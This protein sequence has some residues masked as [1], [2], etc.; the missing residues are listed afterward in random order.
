MPPPV[1]AAVRDFLTFEA[2]GPSKGSDDRQG[3]TDPHESRE[4]GGLRA[5][6]ASRKLRVGHGSMSG[7]VR[8]DRGT[9]QPGLIQGWWRRADVFKRTGVTCQ[10]ETNASE[11]NWRYLNQAWTEITGQGKDVLRHE[12]RCVTKA[13]DVRWIEVHARL[14]L[15]EDER[16]VGTTGT[17]R[18][19]TVA[20]HAGHLTVHEH[21]VERSRGRPF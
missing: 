10:L 8:A 16:I 2:C 9:R 14:I 15:D 18:D 12:T 1:P 4:R 19:V 5:R 13:G 7:L 11:T 20:V 21:D 17:L 6:S 3:L